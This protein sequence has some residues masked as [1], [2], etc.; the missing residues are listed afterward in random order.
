MRVAIG[1]LLAIIFGLLVGRL[2]AS[3]SSSPST[4]AVLK[5]VSPT[6]G[7]SR[8]VAGV[9]VGF[10]RSRPGAV[11]AAGSYQQAFADRSVLRPGALRRRIKVVATPDFASAMV[12]ANEAGTA[13]LA[14]GPF[15][16]G[17]RAGVKSAFF[18]VPVA[19]RLVSYT[20]QRAVVETWGFSLIGNVAS[21]EPTAYFGLGRTVLVWEGGDWKI[22]G[23]RA[24]FGPTPRLA[25]PREGGEG[26]GLVKLIEELRPY[27]IAP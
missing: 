20:P 6:T 26:I 7:A 2:S 12:Q 3:A 24:S 19:Y 4:A 5:P 13:R 17:L 11:L 15:G 1:V 16:Q 21:L 23:T 14:A 27:G 9:P 8:E 10:P 18:G 25:S 22:A